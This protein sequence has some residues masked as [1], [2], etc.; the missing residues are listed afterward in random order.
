MN[1]ACKIWTERIA[2]RKGSR[3]VEPFRKSVIKLSIR[4]GSHTPLRSSASLVNAIAVSESYIWMTICSTVTS[5][6]PR[7]QRLQQF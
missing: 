5:I 6:Y 3:C 4:S 2:P 1:S 7:V